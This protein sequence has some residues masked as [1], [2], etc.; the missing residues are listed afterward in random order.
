M[1]KTY[2]PL[3]HL[4]VQTRG[5]VMIVRLDGGPLGLMGLD[6]SKELAA[7]VDKVESDAAVNAVVLTGTHPGR[8]IGHADV[9]WLQEG[10]R[11]IPSVGRGA[12]SAIARTAKTVRGMPPLAA[13]ASLTPL[14]GGMQLDQLHDTF[15][16][17][18][19]C[20]TIF[21]AA[22]NGSALG[23]GSE[24]AQACDVRLMADGDFFIGQPEVLLGIHPGGGGTQRLTRLVGAH[25]ALMMMLE[26]RPVSPRK[27][28]DI[29]LVD[30]VVP[31]DELVDRAI[32]LAQYLGSRPR[33]A[34]A[35]IKRAVYLGGSMTL[36]EGLHLE[37]TEFITISPTE[38]AQSLMVGYLQ[39]TARDGDLPLYD[40]AIYD[41]ALESGRFPLQD[42]GSPKIN[43]LPSSP[44]QFI[45]Q[46]VRFDSGESY[47]S[48]WL[49][50]PVGVTRPPVVV[51]GH[52]LGATREMR[53]DAFS[54]RF[55][56]AGIATLAF[57][58]RYF[59]D[60]G[61]QPRQLMS[62]KRQLADWEAALDFVKACPD[63]DGSRIAVWGSSFG[64]GHAI[65]VASRHPELLAAVS[66]CPFTDGM[67]SAAAL[68]VKGTM[69]VTPVILRDFAA[70]LLGRP[71]VMVP[72]AAAPGSPALMN[73]PDAL[74]GYLALMPKGLQFV[75]HVAARVLPEIVAY[76]PGRSAAKVKFPI[77]F[78]VSSTDSV[79][80]PAQTIA[81][82]RRAPHGEIKQYAAGHFDFYMGDDFEQLVSDQTQFLTKHLQISPA[83]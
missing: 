59:G 45:R 16:R 21:I 12:A 55:A 11:S 74:P 80:P 25:R 42:G 47:C 75:N 54:E 39:R 65:E 13:V 36:E 78:C 2:A 76:R 53:L 24:L 40:A 67:A 10:G 23:L 82:A 33:D 52:G 14:E 66:Q 31:P 61:G 15:L 7:L 64:G 83:T 44:Y 72:I 46:D 62:V 9:R 35:A 81:L 8:F 30:E 1:T 71:P 38:T 17:M 56:A 34:I 32:A 29:G 19:R 69:Q 37:R 51:L 5:S 68:G 57:T 63:V 50:L 22:L 79:T 3:G 41:E 20:G 60:S 48:A 6:M 73:A 58:Y 28:L 18:N 49:Y 70:R 27:A 26:G 4:D 77:L 43:H